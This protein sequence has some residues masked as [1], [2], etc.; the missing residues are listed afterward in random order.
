M[1]MSAG[2]VSRSFFDAAGR[3]YAPVA[4]ILFFGIEPVVKSMVKRGGPGS[5]RGTH[6]GG[7]DGGEE[8]EL[9]RGDIY[10]KNLMW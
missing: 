10:I 4:A 5:G 3:R 1:F 8:T 7:G 9:E 6:T 2:T